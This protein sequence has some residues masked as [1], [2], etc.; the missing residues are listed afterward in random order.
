MNQ[1][2]ERIN[3][4]IAI[5]EPTRAHTTMRET[6]SKRDDGALPKVKKAQ[7]PTIAPIDKATISTKPDTNFSRNFVKGKQAFALNSSV[8]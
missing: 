3:S 8:K 4:I 1:T 6:T 7:K 2:T 5:V